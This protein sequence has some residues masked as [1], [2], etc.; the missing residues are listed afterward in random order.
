MNVCLY[1]SKFFSVT[2]KVFLNLAPIYF[3]RYIFHFTF[4]VS[5]PI[6]EPYVPDTLAHLSFPL[7]M[8]CALSWKVYPSQW[9][10]K[11]SVT[12]WNLFASSLL[13]LHLIHSTLWQHTALW[14]MDYLSVSLAFT[15]ASPSV[16]FIDW[17]SLSS[18]TICRMDG[19]LGGMKP[20][21]IPQL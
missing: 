1:K 15:F 10:G 7:C 6:H 4:P 3:Y 12:F 14:L 21:L 2:T 13:R 8:C 5:H 18:V 20:P 9:S 11:F 19:G 17:Q 16:P